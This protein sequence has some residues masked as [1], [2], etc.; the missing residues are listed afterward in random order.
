MFWNRSEGKSKNSAKKPG[1]LLGA[2]LTAAFAGSV[3]HAA[4]LTFT[5]NMTGAQETPPN[6]SNGVGSAFVTLDT[7]TNV[8]TVMES[9]A[10]LTTAASAA[11]IHCCAAPGTAAAVVIPFASFPAATSGTFGATFDLN[12]F[13][14]SGGITE[15]AFIAGLTS[16]QAYVNIHNTTFPGG[17]I[18]GQLLSSV[19]ATPEPESLWLLG[20][21]ALGLV[22][23]ARR[24]IRA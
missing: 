12:T 6:A 21:G 20:T 5:A 7:T 10:G 18:R 2:L 16:G 22:G 19:A 9:F 8:L 23:V 15:A 11:H 13:A 14:F 3:C 17:E 4:T 24:R 1:I